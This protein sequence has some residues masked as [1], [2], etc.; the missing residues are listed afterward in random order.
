MRKYT[1]VLLIVCFTL[2]KAQE[3]YAQ[4]SVATQVSPVQE[5]DSS[6][7]AYSLLNQKYDSLSEAYGEILALNEEFEKVASSYLEKKIF[8]GS[9]A[10]FKIQ[11]AF[12]TNDERYVEV[13]KPSPNGVV[14]V[15]TSKKLRP[16]DCTSS[17]YEILI[18]FSNESEDIPYLVSY[19][20]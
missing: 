1:V 3:L 11:Y 17:K 14:T 7:Q 6:A 16:V 2:T 8:I 13:S 4:D 10:A 12:D 15:K 5:Y 9:R 20:K 18:K 19:D